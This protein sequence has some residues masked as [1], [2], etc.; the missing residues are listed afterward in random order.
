MTAE[1]IIAA[2]GVEE[3]LTEKVEPRAGRKTM[4]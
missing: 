4:I 1:A 2:K 3:C